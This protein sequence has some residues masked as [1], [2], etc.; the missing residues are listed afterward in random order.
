M[1]YT[2]RSV[3]PEHKL[4]RDVDAMAQMG[5]AVILI[6]DS[7]DHAE[8]VRRA[9]KLSAERHELLRF[10]DGE[11]ALDYLIAGPDAAANLAKCAVILLDL[12]LPGVSGLEVLQALRELDE[13][14]PPV[15]VL[16]TSAGREDIA[17]AYANGAHAYCV[18]PVDLKS[19]REL[20]HDL[21][22]FWVKWNKIPLHS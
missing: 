6:E 4:D 22:D 21:T 20:V 2:E 17:A 13:K 8:L 11:Q 19:F 7:D 9:L 16:T 12:S 5:R 3:E 1:S 15:V 14:I 18:K 10:E